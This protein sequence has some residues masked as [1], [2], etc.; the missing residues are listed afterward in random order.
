MKRPSATGMC[1]AATGKTD[2]SAGM[3]CLSRVTDTCV[4]HQCRFAL[5]VCARVG[6]RASKHS[7]SSRSVWNRRWNTDNRPPSE[8]ASVGHT[9]VIS[10]CDL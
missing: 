9:P 5:R 8:L 3:R 10:Y 7:A 4:L 2:G 1:V 6:G